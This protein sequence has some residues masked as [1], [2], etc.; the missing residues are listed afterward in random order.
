MS[1]PHQTVNGKTIEGIEEIDTDE[2]Q[3][4]EIGIKVECGEE[5]EDGLKG[6]DDFIEKDDT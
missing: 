1:K 5:G 4:G 3:Q 6:Y 2:K